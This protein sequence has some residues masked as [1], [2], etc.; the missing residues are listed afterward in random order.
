M[1]PSAPRYSTHETALNQSICANLFTCTLPIT[2]NVLS[3]QRRWVASDFLLL[4]RVQYSIE[5]IYI[6]A[7][8]WLTNS[9]D[10][11]AI[12]Y[13]NI[14]WKKLRS[15]GWRTIVIEKIRG[16][17]IALTGWLIHFHKKVTARLLGYVCS[18]GKTSKNNFTNVCPRFTCSM[19]KTEQNIW[20]S[21]MPCESEF[22]EI[23]MMIE[24]SGKD[25]LGIISV[26]VGLFDGL[27]IFLI[28]DR[29]ISESAVVLGK[30]TCEREVIL[31]FFTKFGSVNEHL[32]DFELS[33]KW[34]SR[35]FVYRI[36]VTEN[37][38]RG[39]GGAEPPPRK[40]FQL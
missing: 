26:L 23:S 40:C 10:E 24:I 12:K 2:N 34:F 14:L 33:L 37:R 29:K 9:H 11:D 32:F 13:S 30:R 38:I 8:G 25:F 4:S 20:Y 17:I 1:L 16:M 7:V 3:A 22:V 18:M 28:S 31:K 15:L 6:K 27:I 35:S 36:P 21:I 39:V 5:S 19:Q